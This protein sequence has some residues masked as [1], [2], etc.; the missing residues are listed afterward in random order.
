MPVSASGEVC[1]FD[2]VATNLV[3]DITGRFGADAGIGDTTSKR[4]VDTRDRGDRSSR[5]SRRCPV[6]VGADTAALPVVL[7][8]TA[9][10][11]D[12][13][14]WVRA[15][16]VR[17]DQHDLDASTSTTPRRC[18]TWRSS[19]RAPTARSASPA[20]SPSH[21]IV[22]R[23]VQFTAGAGVEVVA[24]RAVLDTREGA[25]H[26]VAAGGVRDARRRRARRH[27]RHDGRDAQPHRHRRRSAPGSSRPT[28]APTGRAD[29]SNLNYVAGDVVANFVVV[30]A[31]RRRRRVRVRPRRDARRRRPDRHACPTASPA[32]RRSACSTHAVANLPTR[33]AVT[34]P[35]AHVEP[36][37]RT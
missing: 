33:L 25:G 36:T 1:I 12:G 2:N 3:V 19:C 18:P 28:R 13:P 24:P 5:R 31:R 32:A 7:N 11:A 14:G 23:F 8:V 10:E 6:A 17:L 26:A 20:P 29:D 27:R 21:L 16:T 4:L 34:T 15:G 35:S 37:V 22:D 9:V 30:A